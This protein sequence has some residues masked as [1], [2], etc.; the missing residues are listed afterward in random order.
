MPGQMNV[1]LAEAESR[2]LDMNKDAKATCDRQASDL[3]MKKDAKATCDLQ[4][5]P[6][7]VSPETARPSGGGF[8]S[9]A[10][11][12]HLN[13]RFHLLSQ[14]DV[15][16]EAFSALRLS[17]LY[18]DS[19][20]QFADNSTLLPEDARARLLEAEEYKELR[21]RQV[22]VAI[23]ENV[24]T[25][26]FGKLV[27]ELLSD[28]YEIQQIPVSPGDLGYHAIS[29]PRIYWILVHKEHGRFLQSVRDVYASI[30]A[31]LSDCRDV[32]IPFL[33][34]ERDPS[35]LR[36]ERLASAKGD[37]ADEPSWKSQLSGFEQENLANYE[38][39]WKETQ[40]PADQEQEQWAHKM[41]KCLLHG[42]VTVVESNCHQTDGPDHAALAELLGLK[43]VLHHC[44]SSSSVTEVIGPN[45]GREVH[46]RLS[47]RADGEGVTQGHFDVLI[48]RKVH[49]TTG[50]NDSNNMLSVTHAITLQGPELAGALLAGFKDVENRRL[51]F[52]G[53]WTAVHIGLASYPNS[54]EVLHL[55]PG[56]DMST[57]EKGDGSGSGPT[58]LRRL[59]PEDFRSAV[60]PPMA[61]TLD[62]SGSFE[63]AQ[64][65]GISE[66][67]LRPAGGR[68]QGLIK[69]GQD[70]DK[71]AEEW[72]EKWPEKGRMFFRKWPGALPASPGRDL[73]WTIAHIDWLLAVGDPQEAMPELEEQGFTKDGHHPE[74]QADKQ[75]LESRP[76]EKRVGEQEFEG[77]IPQ[78]EDEQGGQVVLDTDE[79][80]A[81]AVGED[82]DRPADTSLPPPAPLGTA[83]GFDQPEVG[84]DTDCDREHE[85]FGDL[86]DQSWAFDR[87]EAELVDSDT[88][89]PGCKAG[90]STKGSSAKKEKAASL[91]EEL[92][93]KAKKCG[94]DVN[95]KKKA[96]KVKL[97]D[98]ERTFSWSFQS[99][100]T[101]EAA[102]ELA[103]GSWQLLQ[104]S[105][106]STCT[107][108]GKRCNAYMDEPPAAA[109]S[110]PP[111]PAAN[112]ALTSGQTASK[113]EIPK[114]SAS[115]ARV[116]DVTAE[117]F[118]FS[119]QVAAATTAN[120]F[121]EQ[122]SS[123]RVVLPR[124]A[125]VKFLEAND[126]CRNM[127]GEAVPG[128]LWSAPM[129]RGKFTGQEF[130]RALFVGAGSLD[131]ER[132]VQ[133][134]AA[135]KETHVHLKCIGRLTTCTPGAEDVEWLLSNAHED[136][137]VLS[138]PAGL[139]SLQVHK[140]CPK[141]EQPVAAKHVCIH[142]NGKFSSLL[143]GFWFAVDRLKQIS[144]EKGVAKALESELRRQHENTAKSL[145][146]PDLPEESLKRLLEADPTAAVISMLEAHS[147]HSPGP[148]LS[149][150]NYQLLKGA[151]HNEPAVK[152]AL[153]CVPHWVSNEGG[154]PPATWS[155]CARRL[156]CFRSYMLIAQVKQLVVDAVAQLMDPAKVKELWSTLA[157]HEQ[158]NTD[159]AAIFDCDELRNW[160]DIKPDEIAQVMPCVSQMMGKLSE[161]VSK[162]VE[163][164]ALMD[165]P[166][167]E[168]K[169]IMDVPAEGS[170]DSPGPQEVVPHEGSVT[171]NRGYKRKAGDLPTIYDVCR[172]VKRALELPSHAPKQKI[173][174]AEFPHIIKSD[175]L[176]KW[177]FRYHSQQLFKIPDELAKK[178]TVVPE[179][180][181]VEHGLPIQ[182]KGP[183]TV[184]GVPKEVA[185]L[186]DQAQA[187][188]AMGLT[189]ATKRADAAQTSRHVKRSLVKAMGEYDQQLQVH[190]DKVAASNKE[191]WDKFSDKVKKH[192]SNGGK[193]YGKKLFRTIR[194]LKQ[195]VA[196]LPR[197]FKKWKPNNMTVH[198]IQKYFRTNVRST[199]TTGNF[200]AYD[201]PRMEASRLKH[202]S[203]LEREGVKHDLVLNFD[204]TWRQLYHP[205]KRASR[206]ESRAAIWQ[207]PP[208]KRIRKKC[209]GIG[210]KKTRT[211]RCRQAEDFR[212]DPIQNARK[213]F[214]VCASTWACGS[215]GPVAISVPQGTLSAKTI[216][217]WNEEYKGVAYWI[218]STT[219]SHMMTGES[220]LE[221]YEN[222]F[223]PAFK[224]QRHA[225]GLT[226][227]DRGLLIC[228]AFT[229]FH[230]G[231]AGLDVRRMR[232]SEETNV[233][234][235]EAQPG[236]W[237]GQPGDRLF[238]TYK[239]RVKLAL[240]RSLG[241]GTDLF[242]R[243]KYHLLPLASTG[244]I[245]RSV[246]VEQ[247]HL[248]S[249]QVWRELPPSFFRGAWVATGY[250]SK[251]DMARMSDIDE[252][253]FA[254]V[255]CK[256]PSLKIA[257]QFKADVDLV[258]ADPIARLDPPSC[259]EILLSAAAGEV[260]YV[261]QYLDAGAWQNLPTCISRL[262]D[263][264]Y[265]RFSNPGKQQPKRYS[266]IVI[267]AIFRH[268][269]KKTW[270][271]ENTAALPDGT[272]TVLPTAKGK[273]RSNYLLA[274]FD[275]QTL[276]LGFEGRSPVKVRCAK[277]THEAHE[278]IAEG[279][280][281]HIF[282]DRLR[283]YADDAD[284]AQSASAPEEV[285]M[286][287]DQGLPPGQ[288]DADQ[289]G[290]GDHE[291]MPPV[292]HDA[293][294]DADDDDDDSADEAA[295]PPPADAE[296]ELLLE[297]AAG[298]A[299]TV[300][301]LPPG[302]W[303]TL[304]SDKAQ[305][306]PGSRIQRRDPVSTFQ[307]H[308][309]VGED[310]WSK[311]RHMSRGCLSVCVCVCV[312]VVYN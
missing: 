287:D 250:V 275:R 276:S 235:P 203:I 301:H 17:P 63:A 1:L 226:L 50:S 75:D 288:D 27:Q 33:F 295:E 237:K 155:R 253:E 200:L 158:E 220:V 277:L 149:Q 251:Q 157:Q 146:R 37:S 32:Q 138:L 246:D 179:W 284:D 305:L 168:P 208:P 238:G 142:R 38:N 177:M 257:E 152:E 18:N 279:A 112:T 9:D 198:R 170:L 80:S 172:V 22:K 124:I 302:A 258:D 137:F 167:E 159:L 105:C 229:G 82:K 2:G 93:E 292:P 223:T 231:S 65:G 248:H 143:N 4:A 136:S 131:P 60:D 202:Q 64:P 5:S 241:F 154:T 162:Q 132:S 283:E 74:G 127:G 72:P 307:A 211:P 260:H 232:W 182:A 243:D 81:G 141:Q 96:F 97:H 189:A 104:E 296:R 3:D 271:M 303:R 20:C 274:N 304:E 89:M 166:A 123:T 99:G 31:E 282:Q 233:R 192:A 240:D 265:A 299:S 244:A 193:L 52:E 21:Q 125:I 145:D 53:T 119:G 267:H 40:H 109:V 69:I 135:F 49:T 11:G 245:R 266:S 209:P 95:R 92:V 201:D 213:C 114:A 57:L 298:S 160:H 309:K 134:Y 79:S 110:P 71:P 94:I 291:M 214:T 278:M 273:K 207:E 47:M 285:N 120:G 222:L 216:S 181:A 111:P 23:L 176:S 236:G 54:K 294:P 194:E 310:A 185:R 59:H 204:Q 153:R 90:C 117:V 191:A 164:P 8:I 197:S 106:K 118:K 29:R 171:G 126:V 196:P 199:N 62:G 188:V 103:H 249:V 100:M 34:W 130:V 173:V 293:E 239:A 51:S 61:I 10:D 242:N 68:I 42:W 133:E 308:F 139:D 83:A 26:E 312:C 206:K 66:L 221:L 115:N 205:A 56:L 44:T 28:I 86:E 70:S 78:P 148:P 41:R 184:A 24:P 218:V 7:S 169:A 186:V 73:N 225:R 113:P 39:M 116:D 35:A 76:S 67:R 45:E 165:A 102:F 212:L 129:E 108:D 254:K 88:E 300:S 262:L 84:T 297:R 180:Y 272:R 230:S 36:R 156:R 13:V 280:L 270:V 14:C 215:P 15:L 219:E 12:A 228:D 269:M 43:I 217:K 150:P 19:V 161:V 107:W 151:A 48:P 178:W 290:D 210:G 174:R 256:S 281:A 121:E 224:L 46:L 16:S 140:L 183:R 85:L 144:L 55:A 255:V 91:P 268:E 101:P 263:R 58:S 259:A 98:F 6:G 227:K 77:E 252:Q 289:D 286:E 306:A 190:A 87:L 187:E 163:L 247:A 311:A 128:Y 175:I 25:G 261:W 264:E 30:S 147:L 234:L 195:R 122:N